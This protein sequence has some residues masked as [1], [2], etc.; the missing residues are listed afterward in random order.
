MA[1]AAALTLTTANGRRP[2]VAVIGGS[3]A[4]TMVAG[5][6]IEQFGCLPITSRS[7]IAVL[8]PL[9]DGDLLDLVVIDLPASGADDSLAD[10]LMQRLAGHNAVPVIALT[11]NRGEAGSPHLGLVALPKPYSPREL[12]AAMRAALHGPAA[13]VA[14]TA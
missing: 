7:G 1:G 13:S 2:R 3:P 14:G 5:V 4:G 10:Q 9:P 6:L 8:A 11:H 12:H